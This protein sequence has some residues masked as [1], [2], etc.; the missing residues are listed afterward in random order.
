V[1]IPFVPQISVD[2]SPVVG[3]NG[4][5][6]F[7]PA[8]PPQPSNSVS[9]GD[10]PAN[11]GNTLAAT[12]ILNAVPLSPAAQFLSGFANTPGPQLPIS[13]NALTPAPGFGFNW[14][15]VG[16]QIGNLVA[17]ASDGGGSSDNGTGTSADPGD[18]N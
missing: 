7:V 5:Q 6:I 4:Q 13:G 16:Q 12:F 10:D 8:I 2:G 9:S 14:G 15:F 1:V 18:D 17:P 11:L 3:V